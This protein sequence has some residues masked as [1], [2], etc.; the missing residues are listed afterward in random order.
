MLVLAI[1]PFN[2]YGLGAYG[3]VK[4]L[5]VNEA[6]ELSEATP[7]VKLDVFVGGLEG[8]ACESDGSEELVL[9][10]FPL[11]NPK[12]PFD[13]VFVRLFC[14]VGE[15]GLALEVDMRG[16]EE[17]EFWSVMEAVGV[18]SAEFVSGSG[19]GG[20]GPTLLRG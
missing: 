5:K 8:L 13:L 10:I 1:A 7:L 17:T 2:E 18:S 15:G 14:V 19:R 16:E 11:L 3:F 4:L 20:G 9:F 6:G 12:V